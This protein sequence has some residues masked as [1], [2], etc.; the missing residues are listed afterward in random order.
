MNDIEIAIKFMQFSIEIQLISTRAMIHCNGRKKLGKEYLKEMGQ[1]IASYKIA[2]QAL[3]EKAERE[4][5]KPLTL[6]QLKGKKWKAWIY[7][8]TNE[9]AAMTSDWYRIFE[10]IIAD[11]SVG[12]PGVIWDLDFSDYGKTWSAYDHEP[13]E[14]D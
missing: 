6:E 11:F 4:N 5:P 3:Q 7:I 9:M 8:K 13:K 10:P 1:R 14:A 12:Y 2:I